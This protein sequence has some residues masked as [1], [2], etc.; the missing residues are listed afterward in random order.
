MNRIVPTQPPII[1]S[2]LVYERL[3]MIAEPDL[4]GRSDQGTICTIKN[5]KTCKDTLI[6]YFED[7]EEIAIVDK[8]E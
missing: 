2:R 3:F 5:P 6:W 8:T 4:E 1:I 7:E